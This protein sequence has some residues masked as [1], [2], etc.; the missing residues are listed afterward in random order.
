MQLSCEV[1]GEKL[2][3]RVASS[4]LNTRNDDSGNGFPPHLGLCTHNLVIITVNSTKMRLID[5][6]DNKGL[7]HIYFFR[8]IDLAIAGGLISTFQNDQW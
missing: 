6:F 8:V 4:H 1:M 3:N 5:N 2:P 7:G